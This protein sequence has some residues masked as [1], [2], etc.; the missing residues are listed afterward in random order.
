MYSF[1]NSIEKETQ[2]ET[3]E[4]DGGKEKERKKE[5]Q[6][7]SFH[8]LINNPTGWND[9]GLVRPE[10]GDQNLIRAYYTNVGR[11]AES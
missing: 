11:P 1:D 7:E 8:L 10:P 6:R 5:T 4:R 9:Q 2:E 3:E